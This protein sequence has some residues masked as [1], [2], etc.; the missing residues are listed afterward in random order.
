MKLKPFSLLTLLATLGTTYT[1][2]RPVANQ[3]DHFKKYSSKPVSFAFRQTEESGRNSDTETSSRI[4]NFKRNLP[5]IES[6]HEHAIGTRTINAKNIKV[7][8]LPPNGKSIT[9]AS[10]DRLPK[11][12][13]LRCNAYYILLRG[14]DD[15]SSQ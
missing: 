11:T 6:K 5:G 7:T 2:A 1:G 4:T 9:S 3:S 12:N 15:E 8:P 14:N 13:L 10:S